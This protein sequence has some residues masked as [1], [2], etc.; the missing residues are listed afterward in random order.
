M[1]NIGVEVT[2]SVRSGPASSGP[3]SGRL[4]IP[5][6]TETGPVDK[7]TIIRSLSDFIEV[8]GSRTSY[9]ANTYD[10]AR[11]FFEE[12]GAE[13]VVSRA[14]GPAAAADFAVL[15][16]EAG[17]DT[18]RVSALYPGR[19]A[20][21]L[22]VTVTEDSGAT[23]LTVRSGTTVVGRFIG[24]TPGEIVAAAVNN[25]FVKVADLGSAT[26]DPD[27]LPVPVVA[28]ALSGG[29]D[30]RANITPAI[31]IKALDKA[32][33]IAEGGA[34]AAPGYPAGVV[35]T[36]LTEHA[37]NRNKIALLAF[38]E[39]TTIDES[40]VA[41][42][43][44]NTTL[45]DYAGI[46]FPHVVIPDG[47]GQRT[48]SPEAY[49]GAVRARAHVAEGYWRKPFGDI[50]VTRWIIGT[51]IPVNREE[52]NKLSAGLV[53]GIITTNGKTRLYNWT[54]LSTDRANLASLRDRDMLNNLARQIKIVLEPFVGVGIDG[55]G[56]VR[57]FVESD[58]TGV[59]EP[60]AQANGLFALQPNEDTGFEGDPGYRVDVS[61][62]INTL[63]SLSENMLNV[64]VSVRMSPTADLIRVEI[65]KVALTGAL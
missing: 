44:L 52:N 29:T 23:T 32:G 54:S 1:T 45:G 58:V 15:K 9:S 43:A 65:I 51:N 49:A 57:G 64:A 21:S 33:D 36:L 56:Q 17:I 14:V 16:D 2:T 5:G 55:K 34:V 26:V 18:L 47:S 63:A 25:R 38:D 53:N 37:R 61:E 24:T 4:H 6:I 30:D 31:L 41:A 62:A 35:G 39:K 7:A 42:T 12:G 48:V 11:L 27:N 13:L 59:L 28:T 60:I 40:I 50:A 19:D 3:V 20:S 22:T 46:I 10:S 8:Y